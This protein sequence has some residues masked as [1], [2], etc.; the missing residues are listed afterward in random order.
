MEFVATALFY[1]KEGYKFRKYLDIKEKNTQKDTPD[2]MVIMM[3]PGSSRPQDSI[4]NNDT[5]SIAVPDST[6]WQIWS[7]MQILNL[8]FARILNLSD[9]REPKSNIFYSR[10]IELDNKGISHSIF[11]LERSY[12]L[13]NLFIKE[14]PVILAWGVDKNLRKLAEKAIQRF[15]GSQ[16]F[17]IRKEGNTVAYYHP[18]PPNIHGQKKWVEDITKIMKAVDIN[19]S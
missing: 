9:L 12:E 8:E 11:S 10:M 4:D 2:L 3:N 19:L 5:E 14:V 18:L 1:E 7:V 6:Q 13:D 15:R 17:G 16:T